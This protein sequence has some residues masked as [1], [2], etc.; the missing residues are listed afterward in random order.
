ME[1][2][3]DWIERLYQ[4]PDLLRMGHAQRREDL[5]LGLGWIYY[6]LA[7][8]IRP[9]SAVVIGS[10][11]G[12]APLVLA[13]ALADNK[14]GGTVHFIDPSLVDD[15]WTDER[16]VQ[17]HFA[18]LGV[19]NIVHHRMTTQEFTESEAYHGLADV[20]IVL[21]DGYHSAEQAQFDFDALCCKLAP[22][23]MILLHDSVWRLPSG[24]YGP[25][26]EYV[27]NVADFIDELKQ[28]SGWQVLDF[29]F[30][31]GLTLARRDAVPTP[32]VRQRR[33]VQGQSE[34]PLATRAAMRNEL[35]A[36]DAAK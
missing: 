36:R 12:F 28:R 22:Q 6:G 2:L 13:R 16:S 3:T 34:A 30:G 15:F 23:G 25:G 1:S 26:R 14:E 11:R 8:A 5:N 24:I 27:H 20:G 10:Y 17:E 19:T 9:K 18:E 33:P 31:D 35:V 29:P 4:Q 32:P 7:R 21:I